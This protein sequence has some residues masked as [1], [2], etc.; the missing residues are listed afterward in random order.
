MRS[1]A[2]QLSVLQG[3]EERMKEEETARLEAA[4]RRYA[5]KE[6]P[7]T[8][9]RMVLGASRPGTSRSGGF[10]APVI[11]V[12]YTSDGHEVD[13]DSEIPVEVRVHDAR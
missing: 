4:K 6:L 13:V 3:Q 5:T 7:T 10:R 8:D 1:G 2:A 9:S 11:T 12:T